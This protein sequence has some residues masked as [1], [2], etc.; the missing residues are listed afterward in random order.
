MRYR[1]N[2]LPLMVSYLSV[3]ASAQLLPPSFF[4]QSTAVDST[5]AIYVAGASSESIPLPTTLGVIQPQSTPGSHGYVAKIAPSGDRFLW[6]TYFG[7][8]GVDSI[9]AIA[10][11]PD[12]NLLLAGTTTSK[13]LPFTG[14]RRE[15]A[16]MFIAKINGAGTAVLAGTYFGGA[17]SADRLPDRVGA[18]RVD[19]GGNII[20]AGT[21]YSAPFPTTPGAYR[22]DPIPAAIAT[23]GAIGDQFVA[24]FDPS[25][26]R[27]LFSTLTGSSGEDVVY[28]LAIGPDGSIHV[29]GADGGNRICAHPMLTRLTS[30]GSALL[31]SVT[32]QRPEA[33]YRVAVDPAGDAFLGSD[34]RTRFNLS[35]L[36]RVTKFDASGRTIASTELPG[37]LFG[38]EF[39]L[40]GELIVTG[41]AAP[42]LL[43]PTPGAP[44]ACL[45]D[46]RVQTSYLARLNPTTLAANYRG[47]L[48]ASASWLVGPDRLLVSEPYTTAREFAVIPPDPPPPGTITC[49]GSAANYRGSYMAPGEI[50][51]IFGN[52][53][54]PL[55][56]AEGQ[57]VQVFVNGVAAPILYASPGQINLV[58]PF[59]TPEQGIVTVE[60][61]RGGALV[62]SFEKRARF[63]HLGLFNLDGREGGV[64]AALNRN[65]SL[66]NAENPALP[67]SVVSIFA[68][69]VGAMSPQPVD[70][71]AVA[72]PLN[73]PVAP[74]TVFVNG[75]EAVVE[76]AGNAPQLVAGAVQIN[77]RLPNP[78]PPAFVNANQANITVTV[79]REVVSPVVA[80]GSIFVR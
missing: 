35:P 47:F 50:V 74:I 9:T 69:G 72:V 17:P 55:A 59:N 67:G 4:I 49:L 19:A 6:A 15:P 56:S 48:N 45:N 53:I 65:L 26:N 25:L 8:D 38:L 28:D 80:F 13:N 3:A 29:A 32:L 12:G 76:Y 31:Y 71:S 16:P 63:A 2:M 42:E 14:Y 10:L 52:R 70:G 39:A 51:S 41:S 66:N 20:L 11:A 58:A 75:E 73:R 57:G 43:I 33:A 5:G 23:C 68:T 27:L 34:T 77:L 64:L 78:L 21:A 61:R 40:N 18:M 22:R 37:S 62:S 30:D 60:V 24:K 54:G 1:A 7:G 46:G 79:G 44:R 36:G